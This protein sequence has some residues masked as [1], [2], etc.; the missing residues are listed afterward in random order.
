M[1][2]PVKPNI[3]VVGDAKCGT[4]SLFRMIQLA[5]GIGT[6]A[7]RKEQHFFSAPEILQRLSGPGDGDIPETIVQD[8]ASYLAA[9]AHIPPGTRNVADVSPS[10]FQTP[11][12]ALRIRRFA[13]DARIVILLR[14]PARKVFSQYVHLW[15]LNRETLPF[16][17]AFARSAERREA[18]YSAM[19]DYEGGGYYADAIQR[20]LDVFGERNVRV[21]IFEDLFQE[22]PAARNALADFLGAR[23]RDGPPPRMNVGGRAKAG[24]LLGA[25]IDNRALRDRVKPYLP[26]AFRSKLGQTLR[27]AVKTEKPQIDP[28]MRD[29]L[30]ALYAADVQRVEALIG[31]DTG[32]LAGA[33]GPAPLAGAD[34][35][36]APGLAETL[37]S[38]GPDRRA[39]AVAPV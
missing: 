2:V 10:Y 27:A 9:F 38:K 32:W 7:L 21:E 39:G 17:E 14:D 3:F 30:R 13:P 26:V 37:A 20:H 25:L 22:N 28:A 4:S 23:F 35:A 18:G 31:R 19:F 1:H 16:E 11:N 15:S 8:E 29:R 36:P 12:A 33:R 24:S 5:E 34:R 6:S